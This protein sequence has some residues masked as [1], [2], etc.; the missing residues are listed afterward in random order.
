LY[1]H[2]Q[3]AYPAYDQHQQVAAV[4]GSAAHTQ[5]AAAY[6]QPQVAYGQPQPAYGQPPQQSQHQSAALPSASAAYTQ[7]H[8]TLYG[9]PQPQATYGQPQTVSYGEHQAAYGQPQAAAYGQPQPSQHLQQHEAAAG[10]G[11]SQSP[12][13]QQQPYS[14]SNTQ[15]PTH[16]TLAPASY[17]DQMSSGITTAAFAASQYSAAMG[18]GAG[19]GGALSVGGQSGAQPYQY[20]VGSA[21]FTHGSPTS[22]NAS[23]GG[24]LATYGAVAGSQTVVVNVRGTFT[25]CI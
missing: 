18:A 23:S 15:Q 3:A 20:Q 16:H 1:G 13:Q 9:Q 21:A 22:G 24:M 10:S 6:G 25:R 5:Q 17:Q 2:A 19:S 11:N 7:A 4:S 14:Y 12:Q 8:Q